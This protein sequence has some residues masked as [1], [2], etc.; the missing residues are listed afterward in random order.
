MTVKGNGKGS[1]GL[2]PGKLGGARNAKTKN[3]SAK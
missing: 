3:K 1:K 2:A